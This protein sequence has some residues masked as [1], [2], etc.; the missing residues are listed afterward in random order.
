MTAFGWAGWFLATPIVLFFVSAGLV[1][2]LL[3]FVMWRLSYREVRIMRRLQASLAEA[4][5]SG[6]T[7]PLIECTDELAAVIDLQARFQALLT[8]YGAGR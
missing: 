8:K 2:A 1:R 4:E 7:G 3:E 5:K 6:D